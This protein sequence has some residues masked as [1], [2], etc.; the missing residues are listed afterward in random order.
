MALTCYRNR[1]YTSLIDDE[2]E[3]MSLVSSSLKHKNIL[4]KKIH[5]FLSRVP[6][7]RR[8]KRKLK[9]LLWSRRR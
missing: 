4:E 3:I 9:L 5:P 2:T 1:M 8:E 7:R 6:P